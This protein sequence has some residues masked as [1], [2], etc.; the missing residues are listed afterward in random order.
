MGIITT[1][2]A[3]VAASWVGFSAYALLARKP[4]VV[5]N[6]VKYGVPRSW[7]T[8]LGVAKALGAA[9]LLVGLAVPWIGVAASVG[10]VLYFA[11]A[12]VTIVRARFYRQIPFPLFYLVPALA[13]GLLF[14]GS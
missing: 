14:T 8:W 2:V 9:G 4:F 5:D 11:G 13:A 3:I 7:W 10:L 1:V 12:V 6:L